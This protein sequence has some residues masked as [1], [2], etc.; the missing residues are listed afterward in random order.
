MFCS[1]YL[2]KFNAQN[3]A[4]IAGP[5]FEKL[6]TSRFYFESFLFG[7]FLRCV[8]HCACQTS[9]I[10]NHQGDTEYVIQS[11]GKN[12]WAM[13]HFPLLVI[14]KTTIQHPVRSFTIELGP[15]AHIIYVKRL[16]LAS[17][18]FSRSNCRLALW[19]CIWFSFGMFLKNVSALDCVC[20]DI[21]G[22]FSLRKLKCFKQASAVKKELWGH[23]N[24]I[25]RLDLNSLLSVSRAELMIDRDSWG[26][27]YSTVRGEILWFF[28]KDGLLRQH[29]PRMTSF[30]KVRRRSDTVLVFTINHAYYRLEVVACMALSAPYDQSKS[31]GSG[32]GTVAKLKLK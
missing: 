14:F 31:V 22:T 3:P 32:G 13:L 7:L 12:I 17:R 1:Q 16:D 4:T 8:A 29:L 10:E 9:R 28:L 21:F 24:G 6:C 2:S 20:S 25:I 23:G 19:V 5:M 15:P 11:W 26:H 30:A 18:R 27:L